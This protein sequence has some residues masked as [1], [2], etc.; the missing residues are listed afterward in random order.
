[1]ELGKKIILFD[2]VCTLCNG[3]VQFIIKRDRDDVFRFAALQ[4][5]LG[6]KLLAER[7]ID[8]QKVDSVVLIDPGVA[9]YLKS[10]AALHI[11]RHLKGY[12][13]FS[14]VLNLIPNGLRNIIYDLIARYRY[15]WFG[16]TDQCVVPTAALRA[17]FLDGLGSQQ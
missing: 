4:S 16:K 2:G 5:T 17:K 3:F 1:M 11:G 7:R 10:E 9:Y 8:V 13:T 6:Q 12:R 14:K 15:A